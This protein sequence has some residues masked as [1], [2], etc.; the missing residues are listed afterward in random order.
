MAAMKS[1]LA[2][3]CVLTLLAVVYLSTTLIVFRPPRANLSV[4]F[5]LAA[6]VAVQC[7][8]TL[9]ALAAN[10]RLAAMRY[11]ILA[12]GGVLMAVGAWMVRE[13]LTGVHFEGY[14]LVLGAM[15]AAQGALT[16]GAF[17]TPSRGAAPAP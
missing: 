7:V 16:L 2:A 11:G 4:W 9:T 1:A 14:A 13:T 10:V 17:L 3:I 8:L 6:I 15:L 5:P 12:G